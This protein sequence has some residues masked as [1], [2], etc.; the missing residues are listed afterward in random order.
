[1][2]DHVA[3]A[4][5]VDAVVVGVRAIVIGV[6]LRPDEPSRHDVVAEVEVALVLPGADAE[7]DV[8]DVKAP[9]DVSFGRG[10]LEAEAAVG[11]LQRQPLDVDE[12]AVDVEHVAAGS[13][14]VED[15]AVL[16]RPADHDGIVG[17][18]AR[19]DEEVARVRP[20]RDRDDVARLRRVERRGQRRGVGDAP[21]RWM[22]GIAGH[23][24]GG[25][26]HRERRVDGAV[27]VDRVQLDV[28][29]RAGRQV[30]DA[31][32]ELL[33]HRAADDALRMDAKE[34]HRV[35]PGAG[36]RLAVP[37]GDRRV[38]VVVAGDEEL[39]PE[40]DQR[41]P[42]DVDGARMQDVVGVRGRRQT[43]TGREG[44]RTEPQH[45]RGRQ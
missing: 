11:V 5:D 27:G 21:R 39:D 12:A 26:R 44:E 22:G 42:V 41:R 9:G 3:V 1:M 6:D 8:A 18:A 13:L 16:A 36:A 43:E 10:P 37:G 35:A 28:V 19:R 33:R 23:G 2:A 29:R 40:R 45:R 20:V 14:A 15:R 17:R 34:R 4:F 24:P 38:V 25:R 7:A 32:G 30:E 31:A